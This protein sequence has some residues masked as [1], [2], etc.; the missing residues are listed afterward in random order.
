MDAI[1]GISMI[2]ISH[3]K[4][5]GKVTTISKYVKAD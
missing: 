3:T 1:H 2:I 4:E 5:N